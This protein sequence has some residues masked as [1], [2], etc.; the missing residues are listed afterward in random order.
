MLNLGQKKAHLGPFGQNK[1]FPKKIK[2]AICFP[3]ECFN[4]VQNFRKIPWGVLRKTQ[5][6][7]IL[8]PKMNCFGAI[9]PKNNCFIKSD[10]IYIPKTKL[11]AKNQ[12][13]LMNGC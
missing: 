7:C 3:F 11:H 4:F 2:T 6:M 13:N 1:N 8:G 5:K 9:V 12:K 10:F